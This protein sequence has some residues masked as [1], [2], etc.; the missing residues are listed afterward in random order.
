MNNTL[1]SILTILMIGSTQAYYSIQ[2]PLEQEKGGGL[3]NNSIVFKQEVI[4]PEPEVNW[5]CTYNS[6]TN[7]WYTFHLLTKNLY[8]ERFLWNSKVTVTALNEP[9][10]NYIPNPTFELDGFIYKKGEFKEALSFPDPLVNA[11]QKS[12]VCRRPI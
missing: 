11:A 2:M 7:Y 10:S 12:E 5:D 6:T 9:V 4:S 1:L 8:S 3:P